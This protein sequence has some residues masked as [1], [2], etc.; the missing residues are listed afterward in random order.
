MLFSLSVMIRSTLVSYF[1]LGYLILNQL[2]LDWE[3][4]MLI[5]KSLGNRIKGVL[6]FTKTLFPASWMWITYTNMFHCH[7]Q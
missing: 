6:L 5:I 1:A 4:R 2:L 3:L 7:L